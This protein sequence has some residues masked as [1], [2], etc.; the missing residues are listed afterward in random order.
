M[1]AETNICT[2]RVH[3]VSRLGEKAGDGAERR[4]K[5]RSV[6]RK[7]AGSPLT[8]G[9]VVVGKGLPAER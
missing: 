7:K 9:K 3:G 5:R 8:F 2:C 4:A 6:I 1:R